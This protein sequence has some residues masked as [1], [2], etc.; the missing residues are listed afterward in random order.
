[1]K[2]LI[3]IGLTILMI[4]GINVLSRADGLS[5]TKTVTVTVHVEEVFGMKIWDSEYNKTIYPVKLLTGT[6]TETE[7]GMGDIHCIVF[8]N[9]GITWEIQA[10]SEG[11]SHS[12]GDIAPL[13]MT[14][15]YLE[16]AKHPVGGATYKD[17]ELTSTPQAVY[18]CGE[19]ETNV[20]GLEVPLLYGVTSDKLNYLMS[21][22][23]TG[24][25]TV[26]LVAL[27]P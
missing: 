6:E 7:K 24:T 15:L 27:A 10:A 2:R 17:V 3:V 16:D 21:G 4:V 5:N 13:M 19:Y 1:M 23:Y 8:A 11:C 22:D 9:K 25:V 12:S 20:L 26:S 14:S 18:T